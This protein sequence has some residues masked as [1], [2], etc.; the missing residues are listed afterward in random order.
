MEYYQW[1][2]ENNEWLT[3]IIQGF[4]GGL[5]LMMLAL[6]IRD[7]VRPWLVRKVCRERETGK[8]V[9]EPINDVSV[10]G[11]KLKKRAMKPP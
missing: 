9:S 3:G 6:M 1:M 7:E 10:D 5:T 4:S 8:M 2:V 11:C